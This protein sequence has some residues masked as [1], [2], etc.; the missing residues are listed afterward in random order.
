MAA[1]LKHAFQN[2][3]TFGCRKDGF[4]CQPTKLFE[5]CILGL[6]GLN[7]VNGFATF[8]RSLWCRSYSFS[9]SIAIMDDCE[10]PF[11]A[12]R[13]LHDCPV[14]RNH[15]HRAS[16]ALTEILEDA[17]FRACGSAHGGC[18]SFDLANNT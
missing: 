14:S 11:L 4:E 17:V 18:S 13:R 10:E 3:N 9:P 15:T 8:P 6:W 5:I 7:V 2:R 12:P 1:S 16:L